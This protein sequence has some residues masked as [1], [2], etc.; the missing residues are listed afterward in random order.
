[1]VEER[2][3]IDD[4]CD[5]DRRSVKEMIPMFL[6]TPRGLGLNAVDVMKIC[7]LICRV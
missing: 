3:N 1:M 5:D 4:D 2:G 6:D 7:L